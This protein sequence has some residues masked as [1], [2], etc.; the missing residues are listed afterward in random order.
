MAANYSTIASTITSIEGWFTGSASQRNN[1]PGNLMYAGQPGAVG[2][3]SNGLAIFT[4]LQD[5]QQALNNQIALDASRGETIAQFAA[6]YA[7]AAAGNDPVSYADQL[8]AA[9]GLSIND[10]LSAA[11]DSLTGGSGGGGATYASVSAI[12][13]G[14]GDAYSTIDLSSLGL[15]EIT[16]S[17]GVL[18]GVGLGL[19]G[20][21][22]MMDRSR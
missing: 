14:A 1:N 17:P 20:L 13:T 18:A 5:G 15:G 7:P 22:W 21:L 16:L 8:A 19:I 2:A 6:K 4:T 11:A 3:D 12:D 10:P 9:T